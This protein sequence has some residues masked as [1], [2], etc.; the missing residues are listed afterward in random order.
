MNISSNSLFVVFIGVAVFHLL[1]IVLQWEE[2]V[3]F[4][5]PLLLIVLAASFF[6]ATYSINNTWKYS[7]LLGLLLSCLGDTLLLFAGDLYFILGLGAF[8]LAHVAYILTFC[9]LSKW[10]FEGVV[11]RPTLLAILLVYWI[12]MIVLLLTNAPKE[13]LFPVL[14]YATVIVTM[15]ITVLNLKPILSSSLFWR[16]F[17]G[18][19][20]F[21]ISDSL[22]AIDKFNLLGTE[23][24]HARFWIMSTYI[25]AQY[26]IA[27]SVAKY[28]VKGA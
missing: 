23:V 19:L 12:A 6:T 2:L 11:S 18:A 4:S 22:I 1:A 16:L 3:F 10:Q 28:M 14:V 17:M 13:L 15:A 20:I 8:L 9:V 21:M 7:M 26:L 24:P 25:T 27:T 5:K